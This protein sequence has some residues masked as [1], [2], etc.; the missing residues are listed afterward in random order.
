MRR[1][2]TLVEL[3]VVIAIIGL[4][5]ALLL[6]AVQAAREAARRT[7]CANNLK[8]V[9]LALLNYHNDHQSLPP[10]YISNFTPAGDDSG[11]G[12]GW[13]AML[14][15]QLEQPAMHAA[16]DFRLPIEHPANIVRLKTVPTMRCPSDETRETWAA[17][18]RDSSGTPT[19]VVCEVAI[20]HFVGMYGTSD[21]GVDGDGVFFRN[22]RIRLAEITDGLSHTIAV[23]ERSHR[24]GEATWVGSVTGTILFPDE[25]E[26]EIGKPRLEHSA[27]MVLG[28]VGLGHGPGDP[29]SEINQFYSLHGNGVNF[30]FVDGHVTFLPASIDY[31][32]YRAM[33]TRAGGE[34]TE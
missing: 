5:V 29:R 31:Q 10:G 23:G 17:E 19:G 1:A 26:G 27:G 30:L 9:G 24:L 8:Q 6:P 3:L 4:L 32:V 12:W 34:P 22:S 25:E 13:A 15:P 21:P 16:I 20:A 2:F 7:Q 18:T 28:H 14:L 33:A 11:P